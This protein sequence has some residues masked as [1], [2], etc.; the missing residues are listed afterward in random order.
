VEKFC[1]SA[2]AEV[3]GSAGKAKDTS[4]E[5]AEDGILPGELMNVP[6]GVSDLFI[7]SFDY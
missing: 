7:W 3:V 6:D 1:A 4:C 5:V 2:E